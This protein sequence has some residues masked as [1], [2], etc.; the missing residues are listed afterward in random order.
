MKHFETEA[1]IGLVMLSGKIYDYDDLIATRIKFKFLKTVGWLIINPL[2]TLITYGK[3][4]YWSINK[5]DQHFHRVK[6]TW[7]NKT[8]LVIKY[9][10]SI[11]PIILAPSNG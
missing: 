2:V 6:V 4:L 7:K 9:K 3:V 8:Y 10:I 5:V 11:I 1:R